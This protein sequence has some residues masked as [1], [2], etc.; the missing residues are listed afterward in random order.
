MATHCIARSCPQLTAYTSRS[1]AR[2]FLR[3]AP[4][5]Y[6]HN[7]SVPVLD[8]LLPSLSSG[9]LHH[10]WA[11]EPKSHH[12]Q[13]HG[14]RQFTF[15]ARR[16][17]TMAI[18]NPRKDEEG[19]DMNI[20]ITPLASH[21]RFHPTS[22]LSITNTILATQRDHGPRPEP[23]PR[24]TNLSRKWRLPWLPIP[25]VSYYTIIIGHIGVHLDPGRF[26]ASSRHIIHG[27]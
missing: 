3:L 5:R 8:F 1:A 24:S 25:N 4:G 16:Q 11:T 27:S 10:I 20:E 26:I 15:S 18:F 17:E 21:V 19:K 7:S 14:K 13:K 23:Q 2:A 22:I 6:L 12:A 9:T